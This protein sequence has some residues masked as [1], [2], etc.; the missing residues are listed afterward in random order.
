M[1]LIAGTLIT[2]VLLAVVPNN[3]VAATKYKYNT[4][5]E[6]WQWIMTE[7]GYPGSL[8][9]QMNIMNEIKI[10]AMINHPFI[11]N[12]EGFTQD[13]RHLYLGLE[14]VNGGELFTYLRGIGRFPVE[15]AM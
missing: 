13:E 10:L 6:G 2:A 9:N 8:E 15:Q 1:K 5:R 7:G 14:L 3:S 4:Y 11:I 12:F